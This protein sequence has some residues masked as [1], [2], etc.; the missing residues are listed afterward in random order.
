MAWIDP[1]VFDVAP[2][3]LSTLGIPRDEAMDGEPLPFVRPMTERGYPL[4]E[5]KEST[6][7]VDP[8]LVDR[9]SRLGYV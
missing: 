5:A 2:R 1:Q 7:A 9:L 3:V 8:E 4:Y 6:A